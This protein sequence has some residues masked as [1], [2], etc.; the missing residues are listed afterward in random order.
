[1]RRE[2]TPDYTNRLDVPARIKGR[3]APSNPEGR[4]ES[5][6]A[7]REDDGW[8][9]DSEPEPRPETS[10]TEERAR[11]IISHN[12]SPDVHFTQSIN[13]YRGCEHGITDY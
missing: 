4:F 13:A 3:G 6:T 11:T 2:R 10:V 7:T 1:M 5:L 12:D 9:Q 8:E